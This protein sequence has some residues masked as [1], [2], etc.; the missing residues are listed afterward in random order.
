MIDSAHAMSGWVNTRRWFLTRLP[1]A[2]VAPAPRGE[3]QQVENP[4]GQF[5]A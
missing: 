4:P 5:A 3:A 1:L 2:P